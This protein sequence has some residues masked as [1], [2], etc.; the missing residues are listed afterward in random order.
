MT[1]I[2]FRDLQRLNPEYKKKNFYDITS[3]DDTARQAMIDYMKVLQTNYFQPFYRRL[4]SDAELLQMYNVGP[5][6]YKK[7]V[8]NPKYAETYQ[9]GIRG[10]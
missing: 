9:R 5:T 3:N 8:R 4:P 7:G 2:A 10:R 1:P 6:A